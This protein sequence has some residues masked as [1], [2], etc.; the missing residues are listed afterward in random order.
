MLHLKDDPLL[1]LAICCQGFFYFLSLL[2]IMVINTLGVQELGLSLTATSFIS[3]SLMAGVCAGSM[4]AVRLT[5]Y[6]RWTHV[7]AP[8][9][10]GVGLS[11]AGAGLLVFICRKDIFAFLIP[12]IMSAGFFGGVF[13]IPVTSFIQIRPSS[14]SKGRIIGVNNFFGFTCMLASGWF[15]PMLDNLFQPS[16]SMIVLGVL[17][18][19]A[20]L[21]IIQLL[22]LCV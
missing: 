16:V 6:N 15:F 4:A 3:V 17:S 7:L 11:L 12:V 19:V 21:V 14:D 22:R 13:L 1:L 9:L 8:A 10:A 20:G 5:S 2:A 18:C